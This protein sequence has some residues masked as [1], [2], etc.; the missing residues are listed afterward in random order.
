MQFVFFVVGAFPVSPHRSIES[1]ERASERDQPRGDSI[2]P[3]VRYDVLRRRRTRR[4]IRRAKS[5]SLVI[6][7]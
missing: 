7:L 4:P 2:A 1:A 5:V 3:V 6:S